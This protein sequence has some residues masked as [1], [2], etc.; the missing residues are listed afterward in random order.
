MRALHRPFGHRLFRAIHGYLANYPGRSPEDRD[1]AYADQI[2]MKILPRLKGL[3]C[4]VPRVRDGL[5]RLGDLIPD[6]LHLSFDEARQREFF[7]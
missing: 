4:D 5:E 6:A 2:A 3:E 1:Q 7:Y